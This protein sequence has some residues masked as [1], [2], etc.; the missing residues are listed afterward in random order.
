MPINKDSE[1]FI[2]DNYNIKKD[3]IITSL[4]Y[5]KFN[6]FQLLYKKK[7]NHL[8]SNKS[9]IEKNILIINSGKQ[10]YKKRYTILLNS[11]KF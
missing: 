10:N 2:K 7:F 5:E 9:L 11:L 3:K 4:G 8:K 6:R 1:E